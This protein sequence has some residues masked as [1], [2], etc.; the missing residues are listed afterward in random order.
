MCDVITHQYPNLSALA[1][2]PKETWMTN[3]LSLF[4]VDIIIYPCLNSNA[5]WAKNF[6][7]KRNTSAVWYKEYPPKSTVVQRYVA[8]CFHWLQTTNSLHVAFVMVGGFWIFNCQSQM[9]WEMW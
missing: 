2:A 9:H 4:D 3:Y 8:V 1:K 6:V 5:I 7:G